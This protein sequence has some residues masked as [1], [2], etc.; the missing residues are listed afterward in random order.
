MRPPSFFLWF[1]AA[2][3]LL[4]ACSLQKDGSGKVE[5]YRGAIDLKGSTGVC[6]LSGSWAYWPGQFV[7]PSVKSGNFDRYE[8][9]PGSWSQ[10]QDGR[11]RYGYASYAVAIEGLDPHAEYAFRFPA[12]SSAVRYYI[13]GAELYSQGYPANNG[14][15]ERVRWATAL[16]PLPG[17]GDSGGAGRTGVVLVMHLSN[18]YD[19]YPGGTL[20]IRFGGLTEVSRQRSLHRLFLIIPFGALLAMGVYFI[21]LF[22]YSPKEKASLWLGLLSFLFA[23]RISCYD[24]FFLLDFVPSLPH[25]VLFRLGYMTFALGL[26]GFAA[27]VR[28]LYPFLVGRKVFALVVSVSLL[29]GAVSAVLPVSAATGVLSFFQVFSIISA[30]WIIRT[31]I[32][33]IRLRL[34]GSLIFMSGF[35]FFFGIVLRDILLANRVFEGVF[36]AH[37]GVFGIIFAMGLMVV[38]RMTGAFSREE[39]LSGELAL[40]NES[41][42]RFIPTEFLS[43]LNKKSVME[44]SLGD[45][46]KKEM[47]ILF[48]HF[49][50]DCLSAAEADRLALL[51]HFNALLLKINPLVRD[52]GGFVDKYLSGG[53]MVLFPDRGERALRCAV[54]MARIFDR[55]NCE[56][57]M[58]FI[59]SLSFHAGLHRGELM[60]G[61]IGERERMEGTVVSDAVN[62]ASRLSEWAVER[63]AA[64][65]VSAEVYSEAG[66]SVPAVFR[67]AVQ[68]RGRARPVSVYEAGAL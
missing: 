54:A 20:P 45:T 6:E 22:L 67:G 4:S 43:L 35:L 60:L 53:L 46:V 33:A 59:R 2:L 66:D 68:L 9:F 15:S 64:V 21:A 17:S 8:R 44:V 34:E 7:Y 55:V 3:S 65:A 51:D 62:I 40:M 63:D 16:V 32:R 13:D 28:S 57:A 11:P 48:V 12:Y 25:E 38:S 41:L 56:S 18:F 19:I 27:F 39:Q 24:E 37:Y 5:V 58:P 49:G 10:Y 47:C 14:A 30:L 61:T 42:K 1:T 26:A 29:Y 50:F 23:L 52:A 31:M 36:L